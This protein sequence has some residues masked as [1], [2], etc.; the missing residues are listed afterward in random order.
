MEK[1]E[2]KPNS[3]IYFL[4]LGKKHH[5]L[6]WFSFEICCFNFR[7]EGELVGMKAWSPRCVDQHANVSP[8]CSEANGFRL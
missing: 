6:R 1:K 8:L 7:P 2:A 4:N 3:A 5:A